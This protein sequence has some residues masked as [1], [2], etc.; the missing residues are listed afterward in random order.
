MVR[1]F[2]WAMLTA[3]DP[4]IVEYLIVAGGGGR[5]GVLSAG[6]PFQQGGGGGAGGLLQGSG[7]RAINGPVVVGAG[8]L[9]GAPETTQF[10]QDGGNSS[11]AG[12]V[13]IGGGGGA[14]ANANGRPGGSGG[15][16]GNSDTGPKLGGAGTPGQGYNGGAGSGSTTS[17]GAGGGAG[18]AASGASGATPGAGINSSITGAPVTFASG[19]PIGGAS[20]P[21]AFGSGAGTNGREGVVV[22]AYQ[23]GVRATGGSYI[24][25]V[26]RPG[27][28]VHVFLTSGTFTV[29]A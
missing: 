1:P 4:L 5:A 12:L 15:G 24:D 25:T 26:G 3:S 28:T 6:P 22:I 13:A 20:T 9:D 21:P 16:A 19:G 11:Y 18:S 8:G 2:S 17:S 23:G 27:W 14:P 7:L 29:V 10:G